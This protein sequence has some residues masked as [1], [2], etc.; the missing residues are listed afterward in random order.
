[1]LYLSFI[2]SVYYLCWFVYVTVFGVIS[3]G[4]QAILFRY[5][6]VI[7]CHRPCI[8]INSDI[9]TSL[10][11]VY[12]C[13]YHLLSSFFSFFFIC[14]KYLKKKKEKLISNF[15]V[16]V[17]KNV[18]ISVNKYT[19]IY[20]LYIW[21]YIFF[22]CGRIFFM[23]YPYVYIYITWELRLADL[24]HTMLLRYGSLCFVCCIISVL[25]FIQY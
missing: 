4:H 13:R 8:Y 6:H 15:N 19:Y 24:S 17:K 25:D 10:L 9:C 5:C 14:M 3:P 20:I 18:F 16:R 7:I 23:I 1:M 2:W 22:R 12:I 21:N 11:S